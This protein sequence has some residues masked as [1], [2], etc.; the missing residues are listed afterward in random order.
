MSILGKQEILNIIDN[1]IKYLQQEY[2]RPGWTVWG[3]WGALAAFTW[4]L[5]DE[6]HFGCYNLYNC[7][8]FLLTFL[9]FFDLLQVIGAYISENGTDLKQKRFYFL[10]Q[11]VGGK[12]EFILVLLLRTGLVLSLGYAFR[13]YVHSLFYY[14]FLF[15]YSSL[16]LLTAVFFVLSF[17]RIPIAIAKQISVV[18][19][20]NLIIELTIFIGYA[21]PWRNLYHF[22]TLSDYRI[23]ALLTAMVYLLILFFRNIRPPLFG[24]LLEL[25]RDIILGYVDQYSAMVQIKIILYGL[26]FSD[27][28]Q[29]YLGNILRLY[30]RCNREIHILMTKLGEDDLKKIDLVLDN[31]E[32]QMNVIEKSVNDLSSE[33]HRFIR[34]I[35]WLSRLDPSG[36]DTL[37][38]ILDIIDDE[39][40][41]IENNI[42]R[43][44][45][46]IKLCLD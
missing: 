12:R 37:K 6:L 28:L 30:K 17:T 29:Q 3:I 43:L 33:I 39:N 42:N 8:Y 13:N 14:L 25:R 36:I 16:G 21:T 1:E 19:L 32:K 2:S 15:Y 18:N 27:L 10:N 20:V 22:M 31:A 26:E 38:S 34:I 46:K 5:L 44:K 45:R 9:I 35:K 24:E 41:R 23:G 40:A 7:F 4:M 11:I